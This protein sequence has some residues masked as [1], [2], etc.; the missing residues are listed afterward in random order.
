MS[1]EK[2]RTFTLEEIEEAEELESGY[3]LACGAMR[4]QCEPD[5]RRYPC[6]ECGKRAVYGAQELVIMGRVV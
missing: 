6:E 1:D 5:A 4:A 2:T 3:C